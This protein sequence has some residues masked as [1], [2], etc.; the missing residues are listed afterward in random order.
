M[1]NKRFFM[2]HAN[3]AVKQHLKEIIRPYPMQE[4]LQQHLQVHTDWQHYKTKTLSG[5][6]QKGSR[7]SATTP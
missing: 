1:L 4:T 6:L 7:K 5:V 3:Q 2:E